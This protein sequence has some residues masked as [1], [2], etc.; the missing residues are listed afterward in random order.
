MK[1]DYKFLILAGIAGIIIAVSIVVI[2]IT[3]ASSMLASSDEPLNRHV[4]VYDNNGKLLREYSGRLTRIRRG[5]NG[6]RFR[7]DGRQIIIQGG[8][9]IIE[10]AE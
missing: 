10:E 2:S 5:D 9:T 1:S 6:I 7:A 8:I 3:L 4:S